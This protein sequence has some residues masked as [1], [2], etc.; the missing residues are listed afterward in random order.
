[1]IPWLEQSTGHLSCHWQPATCNLLLIAWAFDEQSTDFTRCF[2]RTVLCVLLEPLREVLW[3]TPRAQTQLPARRRCR[4][5]PSLSCKHPCP[6]GCGVS[7]GSG[8]PQ[9]WAGVPRAVPRAGQVFTA[10]GSCW[11]PSDSSLHPPHY[12][13][14]V[15]LVTEVLWMLLV[16][17]F[18]M[19]S[20]APSSPA[21]MSALS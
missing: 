1:M 6:V 15:H 20:T 2:H 5:S 19:E 11:E 8:V 3:S 21:L 12:N 10:R 13:I 4:S 17:G 18:S 16:K 14:H 7:S 9:G